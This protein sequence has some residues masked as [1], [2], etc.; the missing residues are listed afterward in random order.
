[1][2]Q[3]PPD[4]YRELAE[5]AI[6]PMAAVG[7]DNRFVWVNSAFEGLLGYAMGEL[8][9][10]TWMEV[11]SQDDVGG[12]LASV[13]QVLEGKIQS[14]RMEKDYIHRRG[15]RVPV[16]LIVRRFPRQTLESIMLFRV[17]AGPVKATRPEL[18]AVQKEVEAVIAD[19]KRRLDK[20][21]Q[22]HEVSVNVGDNWN[23]GDKTGRDKI[24]NSDTAIR[25]LAGAFTAMV[26]IVA[27]LFYYVATLSTKTPPQPPSINAT[28]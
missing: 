1:M 25:V 10:M 20:Y 24:T 6:H 9:S 13:K 8:A 4:F 5:D 22:H 27:Y 11:T 17:E 26:L 15:F 7:V 12:D 16:E 28:P 14:Y 18:V 23:D 21:E 2:T 3:V 19:M